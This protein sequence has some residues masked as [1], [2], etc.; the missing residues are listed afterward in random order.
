LLCETG[1]RDQLNQYGQIN[2]RRRGDH[3]ELVQ[4]SRLVDRHREGK[5]DIFNGE[6]NAGFHVFC[7]WLE[8]FAF[9]LLVLENA[10]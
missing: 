3:R 5:V 2:K 8:L 1:E 7:A 6:E 4:I 9:E 10:T